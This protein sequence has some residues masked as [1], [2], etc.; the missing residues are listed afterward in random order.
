MAFVRFRSGSE[1]APSRWHNETPIQFTAN[2]LDVIKPAAK[3]EQQRRRAVQ[4]KSYYILCKYAAITT[5]ELQI[6]F[7]T[8]LFK[9]FL[10]LFFVK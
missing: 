4:S 3:E 1:K 5:G 10:D 8:F 6:V 2:Y 9:H 7:F